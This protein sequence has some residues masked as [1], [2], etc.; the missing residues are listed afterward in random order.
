MLLL[1]LGFPFGKNV[2]LFIVLCF[3]GKRSLVCICVCMHTHACTHCVYVEICWASQNHRRVA[4]YLSNLPEMSLVTAFELTLINPHF[5]S[6]TTGESAGDS[7]CLFLTFILPPSLSCN[8]QSYFHLD[9]SFFLP[10]CYREGVRML[11]SHE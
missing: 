1:L 9:A 10:V 5:Y 4:S 11:S 6:T 2:F 7:L 3:Q 8:P